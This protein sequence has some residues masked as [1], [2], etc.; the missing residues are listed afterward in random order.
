MA[1]VLERQEG[2]PSLLLLDSASAL[3]YLRSWQAGDISRMPEGYSL[4]ERWGGDSETPTLV[5]LAKIMAKHPGIKTEHV[6]GHRG[7]P[8][9]E[10][11]DALASLAWRKLPAAETRTRAEG[12]VEAFLT[13]WYQQCPTT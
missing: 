10:A 11:A 13:A 9:N 6:A 3:A 4:R 7:H 12:L 1:F 5:R 8:L 2:L